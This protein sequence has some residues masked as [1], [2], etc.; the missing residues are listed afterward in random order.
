MGASFNIQQAV[1]TKLD[2]TAAL[3]DQLAAHSFTP[4]KKGIYDALPQVVKPEL[5]TA[6]PYVVLGGDEATPADT[7]D[8]DAR[9][10][11]I[12]IHTFSR[13]KGD[14]EL[15]NVMDAIKAA[16][17]DATLTVTGE[18]FVLC[19]WEFSSTALEP[20]GITRHGVQRFRLW[21]EGS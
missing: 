4:A 7:D 12:T 8:A 3:T 10:T 17:H 2:G 21:T 20:D 19:Y 11:V 6:F 5:K 14:K 15:R 13:Y 16:L 9:D 18:R 1:F